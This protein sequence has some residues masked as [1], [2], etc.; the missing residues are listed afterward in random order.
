MAA[1]HAG[2]NTSSQW[3]FGGPEDE[4]PVAK[5]DLVQKAKNAVKEVTAEQASSNNDTAADHR[6]KNT[7]SQWAFGGDAKTDDKPA[8]PKTKAERVQEEIEKLKE[9]TRK[10]DEEN[11]AYA[12]GLAEKNKTS[13]FGFGGD[14]KEDPNMFSASKLRKP[15]EPS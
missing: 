12:K 15:V 9:H 13:Q 11:R 7:S 14:T 4:K 8:A 10:Q 2:K 5:K 1:Q 6:G 3:S